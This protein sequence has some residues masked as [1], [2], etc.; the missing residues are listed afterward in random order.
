MRGV[1]HNFD[2]FEQVM[3]RLMML[4]KMGH[5]ISKNEV[6]ILG[7]TFS[8]HPVKYQEI[9]VKRI[10]DAFNVYKKN[11]EKQINGEQ[12]IADNLSQSKKINETADCRLIGLTIETRP[13]YINLNE[14][15]WL[16]YLGVTRVE[17]GVQSICDE[18]LALVRR[19][20]G[21]AEIA[22]ATKLL[23]Q[24]GFKIVY[25]MM[26]GLPGATA[27]MDI[28][29]FKELFSKANFYPDHLKI[30][31]TVVLENSELYRWWQQGKYIP[32]DQEKVI[33]VLKEIKKNI[34]VWVRIVRV[35]RD[36]P[37]ESV[38]AGVKSS[39]L[40]QL[41][42]AEGAVCR[43]IRCR[44]PRGAKITNYKLLITS[45]E[46]AS[47]LEYFLSIVSENEKYIL[48][49]TRLFL[50][51]DKVND[52]TEILPELTG[53]AIIRELHTYGV[54][55]GVDQEGNQ[56][57]HRGMGKELMN[58][59][60]EIAKKNGFCKMAVI[61]GVGVREYYRKIGYRLVGEYM[62]KDLL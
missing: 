26:P 41:I 12:K 15:K 27:E 37:E 4:Q 47:G 46:V 40:R 13:D 61:A 25:H 8:A 9:F 2:P 52:V 24:A 34:P 50:P 32:F 16:R 55:A 53:C 18:V 7:G 17:L 10:F 51:V 33:E 54:V 62:I 60:E 58:K 22:M 29:M 30:Y 1:M 48:A 23:R 20:H 38:V 49:L 28:N 6:I 57:Q 59:A 39:N 44:E 11:R 45:Y 36:I 3:A 5:D 42:Q 14:L 21:V 43:C 19:G 31:P 35:M 56:T